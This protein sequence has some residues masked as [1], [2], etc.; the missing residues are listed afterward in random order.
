MKSITFTVS[1]GGVGK[2]LITA[3]V[4]AAL[5]H[6]NKNVVLVEGDPNQP[7]QKLLGLTFSPN[8]FKLEDVV[9]RD[10]EINK[11]IYPTNIENLFLIPSG[12]SLQ[13]Y[14]EI[15]PIKFA[16][17][18][19]S[20]KTDFMLIDVPFPLG[21]AAFLSLG[22][23]DYFIPILTEDEFV[24]CVESAIDTIRL[25]KYLLKST[26]LGFILN[27]IKNAERFKGQFIKDLEELLE[28]PCITK[29]KEDER[30]SKSYGEAGSKRAF[31]AYST[32]QGSDFTKR[33]DEIA[34]WI[35]SKQLDFKKKDAVKLLQEVMRLSKL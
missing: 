31:L 4:G 23:C 8:D 5:A 7:L 10:T 34:E 33:I 14:F 17:K 12:V 26:P 35:F 25:G 13:S 3:N 18:L 2:S 11:A 20:L 22:I 24:L 21:K 16:S 29:I 32:L 28:I 9:K 15:N 1:K 6:K 30:V 19:S 27:R